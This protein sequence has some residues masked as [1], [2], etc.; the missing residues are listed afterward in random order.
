MFAQS[1]FIAVN[2]FHSP[3]FGASSQSI[4]WHLTHL[5]VSLGPEV[6]PCPPPRWKPCLKTCTAGSCL[7]GGGLTGSKDEW[8]AR[9]PQHLHSQSGRAPNQP[10]AAGAF[11]VIMKLMRR[12][13]VVPSGHSY[14]D[15]A[16]CLHA[17]DT[18]C[19]KYSL[20]TS[21]QLYFNL[22]S[23]SSHNKPVNMNSVS[24]GLKL[25]SIFLCLLRVFMIEI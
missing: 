5:S 25:H 22:S 12:M 18:N 9:P 16:H 2:W 11:A 24:W 19:S 7:P 17:L 6:P 23:Q 10:G 15:Y 3:A 21:R 4:P 1:L 8:L 13:R 20:D 14:V